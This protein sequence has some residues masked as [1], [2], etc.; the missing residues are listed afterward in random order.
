MGVADG[1]VA[2]DSIEKSW[3]KSIPGAE[4]VGSRL[5][6][7]EVHWNCRELETGAALHEED[8]VFLRDSQ[9]LAETIAGVI[10]DLGVGL[11]AVGD[12]HDAHA[13]A[14]E[15]EQ[16]LLGLLEDVQW[17]AARAG[18]EV[19]HSTVFHLIMPL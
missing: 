2:P 10:P 7:E 9:Q 12:F 3:E 16:I 1:L 13:S 17:Q 18:R 11:V 5:A 14:L 4:V 19:V 6:I 15:V 8:L